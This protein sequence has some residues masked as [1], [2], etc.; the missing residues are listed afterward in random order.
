MSCPLLDRLAPE[1]R[2]LI[3]EYVLTFDA[4]LKHVHKMRPFVEK[5]ARNTKSI[6]SI[7]SNGSKAET[8]SS[9]EPSAASKSSNR[10]DTSILSTSKLIYREAIA[11]FYKHNTIHIEASMCRRENAIPLY[12]TDLSLANHVTVEST[13]KAESEDGTLDGLGEIARFA[14]AGFPLIFPKLKTVTVYVNT[15]AHPLPVSALFALT[16]KLSSTSGFAGVKFNGVGSSVAYTVLPPG[17]P[18]FNLIMQCKATVARWANGQ[19]IAN[20]AGDVM[21]MSLRVVHD[22]CKANNPPNTVDPVTRNLFNRSHDAIVPIGYPVIEPNSYEFW[23]VADEGLRHMQLE[24]QRQQQA[25]AAPVEDASS[26]SDSDSDYSPPSEEEDDE[27]D[28]D[29]SEDEEPTS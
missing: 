17:N 20:Y 25:R 7:E 27:D 12:T 10:V 11:V 15:D 2:N 26:D 1:T 16:D 14:S 22:Y 24:F 3:Y 21:N 29:D 13:L 28:G 8:I 23:T 4:P 9:E 18:K 19:A 6:D 5:S